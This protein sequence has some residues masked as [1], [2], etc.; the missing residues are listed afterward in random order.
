MT[1]DR[2]TCC[3]TSIHA[4]GIARQRPTM[5][6]SGMVAVFPAQ[7]ESVVVDCLAETSI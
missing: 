1:L 3:S 4:C 5:V 6:P 7:R 2:P